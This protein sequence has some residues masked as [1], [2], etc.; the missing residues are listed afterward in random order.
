[1]LPFKLPRKVQSTSD[2][3]EDADDDLLLQ[4]CIRDGKQMA[5]G[6][7]GPLPRLP[8]NAPLENAIGMLRK[9][10]NAYIDS[11]PDNPSRFHVEDSPC[12]FSVVS[13]LSGLTIATNT[14]AVFKTHR[15]VLTGR[16]NESAMK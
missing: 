14:P 6:K 3:D 5:H 16:I 9:G 12:N 1:M 2:E 8:Q 15:F 13:E 7:I 11:I 4:T 10:G